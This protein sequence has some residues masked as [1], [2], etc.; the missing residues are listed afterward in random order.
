M[1]LSRTQTHSV[2]PV[3]TESPAGKNAI[4]PSY[5]EEKGKEQTKHRRREFEF[6]PCPLQPLPNRHPQAVTN[7]ENRSKHP[8]ADDEIT[9]STE[10]GTD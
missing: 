2:R 5:P 6:Q 7:A 9:E 4:R 10:G 8:G 1:P 3:T